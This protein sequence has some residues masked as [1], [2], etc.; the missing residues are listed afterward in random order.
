[1]FAKEEAPATAQEV[2][3]VLQLAATIWNAVVLDAARGNTAWVTRVRS[4]V[5]G[6][7]PLEALVEQMILRKRSLFGHD[8]RLVGDF[9]ILGKEGEWRLRVEARDPTTM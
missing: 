3:K 8:L 6:H 9:K 2:E 5:A 7:P 4:Q 1:M